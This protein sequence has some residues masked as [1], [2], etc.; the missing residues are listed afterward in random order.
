MQ[1][2]ETISGGVRPFGGVLCVSCPELIEPSRELIRR[3]RRLYDLLE[4][5]PVPEH[6]T[7]DVLAV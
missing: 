5:E 7:I 2:E 4:P 1:W 6:K 3:Q